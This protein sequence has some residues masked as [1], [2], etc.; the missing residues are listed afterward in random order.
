MITN[1]IPNTCKYS[2]N[3]LKKVVHIFSESENVIHID[4]GEAYVT[5]GITDFQTIYTTSIDEKLNEN[6]ITDELVNRIKNGE[7]EFERAMIF[8]GTVCGTM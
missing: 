2:V 4:N 6:D 7:K 1:Y 8:C 3:N 5:S